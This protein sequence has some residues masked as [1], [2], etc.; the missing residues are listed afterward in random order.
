[1]TYTVHMTGSASA[2]GP[3]IGLGSTALAMATVSRSF[4]AVPHQ[5]V[6]VGSSDIETSHYKGMAPLPTG[7]QGLQP[8]DHQRD[9]DGG[10][11]TDSVAYWNPFC[12]QFVTGANFVATQTAALSPLYQWTYTGAGTPA[13][14]DQFF[15]LTAY[16][17]LSRQLGGADTV[18]PTTGSVKVTVTDESETPC[19]DQTNTFDITWHK[20]FENPVPIG[21][22]DAEFVSMGCTV[23]SPGY[24][25]LNTC[26]LASWERPAA[27][28]SWGGNAFSLVAP[29][30]PNPVWKCLFV[31]AG[32]GIRDLAPEPK[33]TAVS[34]NDCWTDPGST[35]SPSKN[36][37]NK[38]YYRMAP[39]LRI[40]N[41]VQSWCGDGYD[42][43]GY[44]GLQSKVTK[45]F[46]IEHWT[47]AFTYVA[48][49]G[50]GP[51]GPGIMP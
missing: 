34:F 32:I 37:A 36:E 15:S 19:P 51:L 5:Q 21:G 39:V 25:V 44:L 17:T 3:P 26:A 30:F 4:H 8:I 42:Q 46:R 14:N 13:A 20:E 6:A 35:F 47:G 18:L 11:V 27:Y 2:S 50:G 28:W 48:P 1:M 16:A 9:P 22:P 24:A 12:N 23:A 45:R 29:Y 33:Q 10:I 31:L 7:G 38:D 49:G 40:E 43:H 41:T